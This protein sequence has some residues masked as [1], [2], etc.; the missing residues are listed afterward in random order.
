MGHRVRS[1]DPTCDHCQT[2]RQRKDTFVVRHE[3]GEE[4]LIGR[5]CLKDFLGHASAEALARFYEAYADM[6]GDLDDYVEDLPNNQIRYEM[7]FDTT[8]YLAIV[9]KVIRERGWLP[10]SKASDFNLA[11][12]DIAWDAMMD[13]EQGKLTGPSKIYLPEDG[14]YELAKAAR[15]WI[16]E[17]RGSQER[18]RPQPQDLHGLEPGSV[19][20]LGRSCLR[21]PGLQPAPRSGAK[22]AEEK[23]RQEEAGVPEPKGRVDRRAQ[24]AP[25]GCPGRGHLP[26]L[27]R[28]F[29][30]DHEHDQDDGRRGSDAGLGSPAG[31]PRSR[32]ATS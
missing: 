6:T 32:S 24:A 26:E 31:T 10:R 19:P 12:A 3:G 1:V 25:P 23:R 17:K 15:Q 18:L 4:K 2:N 13:F 5:Q 11:T 20:D 9:S 22:L 21:D 16:G 28:G 29:L 27:V 14:D 7:P 30:R 8:Y